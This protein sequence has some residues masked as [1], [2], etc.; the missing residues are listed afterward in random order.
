LHWWSL[1]SFSSDPSPQSIKIYYWKSSN[2]NE[3]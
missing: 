1:Q 3:I 2:N